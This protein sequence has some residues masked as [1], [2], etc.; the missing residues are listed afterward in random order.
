LQ[1]E[2]GLQWILK[3]QVVL[4]IWFEWWKNACNQKKNAEILSCSQVENTMEILRMFS[5]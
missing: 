5:L 1:E 3:M 4:E 2:L